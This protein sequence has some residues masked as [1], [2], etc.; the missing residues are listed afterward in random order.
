VASEPVRTCV[1]CRVRAPRSELVR[2]VA[3]PEGLAIDRRRSAPG[4]GAYVHGVTA[5]LEIAGRAG[6]LA[7]ALRT[8]PAEDELGRLMLDIERMGAE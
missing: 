6:V 3:G 2:I 5:C 1:G 8:S 7:K 4:R